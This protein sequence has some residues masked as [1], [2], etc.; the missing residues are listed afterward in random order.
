M[1]GLNDVMNSARSA[2]IAQQLA[3]EVTSNNVANANTQGYSRQRVDFEESPSVP[4]NYGLLG[5]GVTADNIGGLRDSMIDQQFWG[6]SDSN[7]MA[8]T[9]ETILSQVEAAVNEP[10]D[11]GL[12]ETM[13]SFFSAFQSLSAQPDQSAA[14]NNVVQQGQLLAQSFHSIQSSIAQSQSNIVSDVQSQLA[15]INQLTSDISNLDV[16][17]ANATSQGMQASD[18]VDQRDL[19]IDTLSGLVKVN[20]SDEG[21]GS[22]MVSVGGALV[23]SKSG[24]VALTS[25]ITGSQIQIFA[26]SSTQPTQITSGE[27]GGDLQCY[28]TT[29]PGY[30]SSLNATAN[31]LITQVNTLHAAGYGIDTPPTTGVDFFTGTSASDI[32]VNSAVVND[33]NEIAASSDGTAGDNQ[34]ALALANLQNQPVMNG[35][36]QTIPQYYASFV[37]SVGS[38]IDAAQNT[39]SN[40]QLV[41]N[42]LQTQRSS[43]SGVSIDEE[44][45]NLTMF[46]NAYQAASEVVNVVDELMQTLITMV[47]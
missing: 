5:T 29:I 26:G 13:N 47:Q 35:G 9:Q 46:Q 24:A 7:G 38:A 45:T 30:L 11:N 33:P 6:A 36:T 34:V 25:N 1:A 44:M 21:D 37:S 31:A 28:N 10:S 16:K 19:K 39:S 8:T 27:L 3:L 40:Q 15:N 4:T 17:I 43:V 20:V 12:S 32:N 42:Q 41:I 22:V 14:R 2:L 23:A 18:L